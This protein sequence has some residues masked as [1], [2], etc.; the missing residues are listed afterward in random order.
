M[1]HVDGH[2]FKN[3]FGTPEMR[4]VFEE[5]RFVE[6]FLEVEAALARA[7]ARVG[8]IPED[9][10]TEISARASLEYV[11]MDEVEA[12]V[13]EIHLFTMA[14]IDA[15]KDEVGEAGEYIHWGA[16]SQ[17]ISDTAM[18]L[19]VREG[20]GVVRRDLEAIGDI[21]G[22][23]AVDHAET[24]MIG[25]THHVHA[26]PMTFGLKAATWL[27]EVERHLDR[28]DDLEDRLFDLQFFGAVGTLASLGEDGLAVQEALA[29]ELDLDVPNVAWYAA[30]DRVAE[31]VTTL[32][33]IDATLG[34]VASQVL[35]YNRP[36]V[37]ELAEPVAEGE[38][39]SSTMPHK[40]NPVKS[41]ESRMLS[42]LVR[43]HAGTML[44]ALG[45]YD[46][47]DASTWFAEFAVVP[48]TFLYTS[49]ILQYVHEVLA[50]LVVDEDAMYENLH[51]HGG[52]V[53]SEAVMM[54]LADEVGR[55]TA[56][57]ILFATASEAIQTDRSFADCLK[58][59]ER[60]TA[61]L[62]EERID[63]LTDPTNYTGLSASLARRA[64]D[65]D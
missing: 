14:I 38:I 47:R 3:V 6:R 36:E 8:V 52:L 55:Q 18:L 58:D 39:G 22:E 4:G 50:D 53:A 10:A 32:A 46:E 41:E 20:L 45:G 26:L 42:R 62:S 21:L 16:T 13:E 5:D 28:L 24:P 48:E 30:R 25:R 57:E 9:A 15:W 56:H 34:K 19:Q 23:L 54:E 40:R 49:R 35:L 29:D 1:F 51:V 44:E 64:A 59:D 65:S 27:D 2:L 61:A 63:E 31:L 7:E 60:V 33:M 11:D 43:S 17:D 37:G 12:N